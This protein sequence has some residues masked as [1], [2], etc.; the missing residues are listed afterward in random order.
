MTC[1]KC[2]RTELHFLQKKTLDEHEK[3]VQEVMKMMETWSC[4]RLAEEMANTIM[5]FRYQAAKRI[6]LERGHRE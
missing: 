5:S 6:L 1:E 2:G 3:F 4:D